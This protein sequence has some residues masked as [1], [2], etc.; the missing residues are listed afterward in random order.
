MPVKI[1]KNDKALAR[2]I[3]KYTTIMT[4]LGPTGDLNRAI[5]DAEHYKKL[6]HKVWIVE[7]PKLKL[8]YAVFRTFDIKKELK[9]TK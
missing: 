9:E 5:K 8:R 7:N 3:H 6:G 1:W 2:S 4:F